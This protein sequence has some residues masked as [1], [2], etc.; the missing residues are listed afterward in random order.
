M[1]RLAHTLS[2]CE[3]ASAMSSCPGTCR[4]VGLG[5]GLG[6]GSGSGSGSGLGLGWHLPVDC[7]AVDARRGGCICQQPASPSDQG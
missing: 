2:V 1:N 6:L 7:G 5:L 4:P 3:G